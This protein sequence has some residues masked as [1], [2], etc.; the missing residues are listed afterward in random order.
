MPPSSLQHTQPLIGGLVVCR[1]GLVPVNF[2]TEKRT[3]KD[4]GY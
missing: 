3:I 1:F 2:A 4:S